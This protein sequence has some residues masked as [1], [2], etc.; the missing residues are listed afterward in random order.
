MFYCLYKTISMICIFYFYSLTTNSGLNA[1][2]ERVLKTFYIGN[3]HCG[4]V[5]TNL[6][7][8]HEDAGS[9]PGLTQLVRDPALLSCGIAHRCGLGSCIAV[10]VV[11]AGSCSSD[12]IASLRTSIYHGCGPKNTKTKQQQFS[13][14]Y[15]IS[16]TNS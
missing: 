16:K 15:F 14:Y 2:F 3:C 11:Q 12:M 10:A 1:T 9:I 5:E 7:S 13:I 6:T 4:T 8:I